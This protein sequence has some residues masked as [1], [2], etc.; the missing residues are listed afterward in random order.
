MAKD[1]TP[2]QYAD[3][4]G[5]NVSHVQRYCKDSKTLK[6]VK[7]VKKFGRSY[8]LVMEKDYVNKLQ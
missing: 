3:L 8:V 5:I 6:G 1:L 4:R 2:Q 7:Q